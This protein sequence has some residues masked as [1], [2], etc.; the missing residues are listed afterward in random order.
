MN[1]Y[2]LF[3]FFF[4]LVTEAPM[5][6]HRISKN[7]EYDLILI[8]FAYFVGFLINRTIGIRL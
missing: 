2:Q 1:V 4:E 5:K 3:N 7:G 6:E 8:N